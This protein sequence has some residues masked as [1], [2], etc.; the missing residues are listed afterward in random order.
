MVLL[1][2]LAGVLLGAAFTKSNSNE[3][4]QS[5]KKEIQI[6]LTSC[7]TKGEDMRD[8]LDSVVQKNKVHFNRR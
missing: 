5:E 2:L 8:L 7:K 6:T 3:F 4:S 1:A